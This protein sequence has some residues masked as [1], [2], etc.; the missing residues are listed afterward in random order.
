[1]F[2]FTEA[3]FA[4]GWSIPMWWV[5]LRTQSSLS[6]G[7]ILEVVFSLRWSHSWGGLPSQVVSPLRWSSLSGGLLLRWSSLSGGLTLEVVSP[8]TL[9]G[10]SAEMIFKPRLYATLVF[11]VALIMLALH[12][13]LF[14]FCV[15]APSIP[16]TGNFVCTCVCVCVCVC[17]FTYWCM[18]GC[19]LSS[20]TAASASTDS[21][22]YPLSPPFCSAKLCK[23]CF[24]LLSVF[25]LFSLSSVHGQSVQRRTSRV[26][27]FFSSAAC[28]VARYFST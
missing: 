20:R 19:S 21:S 15:C 18:R 8:L 6:G 24:V 23:L 16:Y 28:S 26:I 5:F 4:L 13:H 12:N 3:V 25:S 2:F 1:M 22:V 9:G 27:S 10:I 14:T 11:C 17:V 7:L